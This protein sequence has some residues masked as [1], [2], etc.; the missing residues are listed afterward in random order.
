[1]FD[2]VPLGT[3]AA[4][5]TRL[6]H[7][8]ACAV[9]REGRVYLFDCGEGTQRRLLEAG[10]AR[11]HLAAIFITHLH[12]DHVFGLPGLLTSLA[13]NGREAPLVLAG[14][15]GLRAMLA[16][17]PGTGPDALPF[18]VE[19]VELGA[20]FMSDAAACR[21]VF[22]DG[23]VRVEARPLEHRVPCAGY[24]LEEHARPG[25]IDGEGARAA[26]VA[27]GWQ[28][29]ALKRGAPVTLAG[30]RVVSPEGLVG[31]ERPGAVFAYVLDTRPCEGGRR[32]ARGADLLVHEATFTQDL[33]ARAAETAHST[34]AEAAALAR[35]AGARRLLLTHVSARYTEATPLAAEAQAVFPAADVAEELRVYAVAR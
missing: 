17:L 16:A 35:E 8:S 13:L 21:E 26:G 2:V 11:G 20:A 18:G 34:A 7:L 22:R 12:G 6:R 32:L 29:E 15:A 9:R 10:L 3:G 25:K 30:G 23:G 5:P 19:H 28:F 31:P 14:P 33:A 24:R 1:M 4:V 27:E